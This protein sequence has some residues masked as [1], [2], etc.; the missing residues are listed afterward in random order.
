MIRQWSK[1]EL[2]EK[3]NFTISYCLSISI[4]CRFCNQN[5]NHVNVSRFHYKE[6]YRRG[7]QGKPQCT[8]K[9]A[10]ES[11]TCLSQTLAAIFISQQNSGSRLYLEEKY[12]LKLNP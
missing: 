7:D 5:H 6:Y 9:L 11:N 3:I 12:L 1:E 4:V 2:Q 8:V 10:E